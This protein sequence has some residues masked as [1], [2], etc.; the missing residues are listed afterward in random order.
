[1]R[2]EA[3]GGVQATDRSQLTDLAPG[4]RHQAERAG[5][6]EHPPAGEAD[7]GDR[8]AVGWS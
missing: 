3:P 7:A 5:R 1:M 6:H 8:K 2:T 4:P